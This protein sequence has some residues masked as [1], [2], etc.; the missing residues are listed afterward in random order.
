MRQRVVVELDHSIPDP[1]G[2]SDKPD[3]RRFSHR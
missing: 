2:T 1:R 3:P